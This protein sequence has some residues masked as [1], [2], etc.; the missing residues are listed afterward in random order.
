MAMNQFNI[1]PTPEVIDEMFLRYDKSG[2]GELEYMELLAALAPAKGLFYHSTADMLESLDV[3]APARVSAGDGVKQPARL[4]LGAPRAHADDQG[5]QRLSV[6]QF[7]RK[8]TDWM[9]ARG[10][11][12]MALRKLFKELDYDNSGYI[13]R[14]E[15]AKGAAH[16]H[17][18]KEFLA[19]F[20][21]YDDDGNGTI[22][23]QESSR[24]CYPAR[25]P[26]VRRR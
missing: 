7:K 10:Q 25:L 21:Y 23:L 8:L 13:D 17:P 4:S 22:E 24:P 6:K 11:G 15:F 19:I 9:A 5:K 18:T 14:E 3:N 1:A 20:D 26:R 16:E 12:L 2:E